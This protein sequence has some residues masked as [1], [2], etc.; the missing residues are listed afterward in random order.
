M[1]LLQRNNMVNLCLVVMLIFFYISTCIRIASVLINI[2]LSSILI[3]S[4]Y[5]ASIIIKLVLLIL[6]E[7]VLI[8]IL[9]S[10]ISL[11]SV[12]TILSEIFSCLVTYIL[13]FCIAIRNYCVSF[14]L[15]IVKRLALR[16]NS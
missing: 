8:F 2:F 11:T 14:N 9:T 13:P 3:S 7:T 1:N 6:I 5:P 4:I 16:Y 10:I 15:I 12:F